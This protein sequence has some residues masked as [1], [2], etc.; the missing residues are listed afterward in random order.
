MHVVQRETLC[1]GSCLGT[2]TVVQFWTT[3][4]VSLRLKVS[5]A[6]SELRF[7]FLFHTPRP[8]LH[9]SLI[10]NTF[11][12]FLM[13][14]AEF[15]HIFFCNCAISLRRHQNCHFFQK[16]TVLHRPIVKMDQIM[17]NDRFF[18]VPD[19]SLWYPGHVL[20]FSMFLV[21]FFSPNLRGR[22]KKKNKMPM[23]KKRTGSVSQTTWQ[24][25]HVT[26]WTDCVECSHPFVL[27]F[28]K[29]W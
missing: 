26:H 1:T 6:E 16:D 5:Y 10:Y 2:R 4:K 14:F 29:Q 7:S 13:H 23:E 8:R 12:S 15:S 17:I 27:P 22:A 3:L 11:C 18:F 24:T 21:T 20:F 9:F 28:N 19:F 25:N